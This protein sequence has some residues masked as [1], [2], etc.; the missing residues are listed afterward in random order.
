MKILT[1]LCSSKHAAGNCPKWVVIELTERV[2]KRMMEIASSLTAPVQSVNISPADLGIHIDVYDEVGHEMA[3]DQGVAKLY[4][5]GLNTTEGDEDVPPDMDIR[6]FEIVIFSHG[7][8][9]RCNTHH[10]WQ[11]VATNELMF[12]DVIWSGPAKYVIEMVEIE[13]D[14]AEG[15]VLQ[16]L[17]ARA[18][19]WQDCNDM[20][21][22][23]DP[24]ENLGVFS[25]MFRNDEE[26]EKF[27]LE[28]G[29]D[30]KE[31][32]LE[33]FKAKQ[34]HITELSGKPKLFMAETFQNGQQFSA[35][36]QNKFTAGMRAIA[37][38]HRGDTAYVPLCLLA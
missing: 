17:V 18:L 31:T 21:N 8:V 16:W 4:C 30:D 7:F 2:L 15:H 22:H 34:V 20:R 24:E 12:Q 14:K 10:G 9:V 35:V 19:G 23:V 36:D 11:I 13:V 3:T 27:L 28:L 32:L 33:I 26:G 29:L 1:R 6:D 37:K 5:T 38:V 25:W